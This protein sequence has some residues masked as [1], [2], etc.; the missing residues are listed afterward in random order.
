VLNAAGNGSGKTFRGAG[1]AEIIV[2]ALAQ[3]FHGIVNGGVAGEDDDG[4]PGMLGIDPGGDLIAADIGQVD[5]NQG[6]RAG[7]LLQAVK[8]LFT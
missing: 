5:V 1:F 8:G 2:D 6:G 4:C 3:R 7:L